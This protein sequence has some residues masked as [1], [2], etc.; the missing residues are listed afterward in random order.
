VGGSGTWRRK[1]KSLLGR[2]WTG[3]HANGIGDGARF[4][5]TTAFSSR[6]A[7]VC[8]GGLEQLDQQC[9]GSPNPRDQ[10][11]IERHRRFGPLHNI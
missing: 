5:L 6:S 11:S 4:R 1:G 2:E 3:M 10:P 8:R 7:A 9:G